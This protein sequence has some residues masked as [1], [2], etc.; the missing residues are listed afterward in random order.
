M[1]LSHAP[2]NFLWPFRAEEQAFLTDLTVGLLLKKALYSSRRLH[3]PSTILMCYVT[4]RKSIMLPL[5]GLEPIYFSSFSSSLCIHFVSASAALFKFPHKCLE[6]GR[7][8]WR[9]AMIEIHGKFKLENTGMSDQ[10]VQFRLFELVSLSRNS[11]VT[12]IFFFNAI[13]WGMYLN[14]WWACFARPIWKAKQTQR[15]LVPLCPATNLTAP[16]LQEISQGIS[17]QI[18]HNNEGTQILLS[19]N[20]CSESEA[21][22]W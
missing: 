18:L 13:F 19:H 8:G 7:R 11:S 15:S 12:V 5:K 22:G 1:C 10:L 2:G 17:W 3:R 16:T 20:I 14:Y 9:I 21:E 4:Y 6:L